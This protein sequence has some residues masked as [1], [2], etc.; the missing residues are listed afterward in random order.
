MK[1]KIIFSFIVA[2]LAVLS[3][4]AQEEKLIVNA[5]NIEH[6]AVAS[7]LYVVLVPS[8]K[9]DGRVSLDRAASD[10]LDLKVSKN[11]LQISSLRPFGKEKATVYLH[12]NKLKSLTVEQNSRVKTTGILDSR[13]L[14]VY[15]DGEAWVHVRTTGEVDAHALNGAELKVDYLTDRSVVKR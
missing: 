5:G 1:K 3:A 6:I 14:D 4:S 13:K 2:A 11:K 9:A 15:V 7:N 8:D 12:V 10:K